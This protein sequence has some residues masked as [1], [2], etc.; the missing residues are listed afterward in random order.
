MAAARGTVSRRPTDRGSLPWQSDPHL[1]PAQ[2][3]PYPIIN[4]AAGWG[5]GRNRRAS[6]ENQGTETGLVAFGSRGPGKQREHSAYR[7][8]SLELGTAV[9]VSAKSGAQSAL[10]VLRVQSFSHQSVGTHKQL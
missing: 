6:K 10:V 7:G 8:D 9:L 4:A 1:P 3:N 5:V 2:S